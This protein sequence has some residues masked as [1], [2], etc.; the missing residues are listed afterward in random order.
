MIR[1]ETRFFA[2]LDEAVDR[3]ADG[4]YTTPSESMTKYNIRTIVM[5]AQHLRRPLTEK[6][7]KKFLTR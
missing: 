1:E 2:R 4:R 3:I 5:E 6:E 7:V